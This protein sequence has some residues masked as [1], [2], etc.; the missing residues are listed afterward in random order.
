MRACF[1]LRQSCK[2]T[3]LSWCSDAAMVVQDGAAMV[4]VDGGTD[5][6]DENYRSRVDVYHC[7]TRHCTI[8]VPASVCHP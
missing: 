4:A 8:T 6:G 1:W 7:T 3:T 2:E 5:F